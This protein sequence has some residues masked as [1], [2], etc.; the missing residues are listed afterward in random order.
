MSQSA[1]MPD[2]SANPE[3]LPSLAAAAGKFIVA[4]PERINYYENYARTLAKWDLLS[5]YFVGSRRGSKGIPGELTYLNPLFGLF[6]NGTRRVLP[7]YAAEWL[8]AAVHPLF[9]RW[10]GIDVVPGTHVLSS[11]GYANRCFK[12]ARAHGGKTFLEAGNSHPENFWNIVKE[13]HRRWKV[14]RAPLPPIWNKQGREMVKHTDYV[15]SPSNYVSDSFLTRGFTPEQ[16]FHIPF[17]VDLNLFRPA[18]TLPASPSPIR[19]VCTGSVSLRKGFPYLLEAARIIRKE[20]DVI[21]VLTDLVESSMKDILPKFSDVPIEWHPPMP[22]AQLAAHLGMCHV[23]AL[24]SL[25]EGFARTAAEALACG[26]PAVLTFNTGSADCI[27]PGVNGE[28]VPI[29]DAPATAAAILKC[30]DRLMKDGR[31]A[32]GGIHDYLSQERFESRFR[33]GLERI[34][35]LAARD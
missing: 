26:L 28:I 10:V 3:G 27:E 6:I 34:G 13:E 16:I 31:P 24:L 4:A 14:R 20:H 7:G 19:V 30:Y 21:L 23:F 1:I 32:V 5:G 35:I 18:A 22:Q 11:Y 29:R 8:R 2:P 17:A 12:K 33:E 9:D 25:E 15:L